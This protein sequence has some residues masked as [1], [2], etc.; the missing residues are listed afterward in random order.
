MPAKSGRV[1]RG[2]TL[3]EMVIVIV[4]LGIALVGVSTALYPRSQQTAEQ[5]LSV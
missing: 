2:F 3:V 4:V 5:V 1:P